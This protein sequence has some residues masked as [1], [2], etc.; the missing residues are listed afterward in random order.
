L[1]MRRPQ[2]LD[3]GSFQ[4]PL[5]VLE[6]DF[7]PRDNDDEDEDSPIKC[8]CAFTDVDG[9]TVLCEECDTWQHIA[10]Y[11]ESASHV[12][13][14]HECADC[15]PRPVDAKA[16]KEYQTKRRDQWVAAYGKHECSECGKAFTRANDLQRHQNSHGLSMLAKR[17]ISV[18]GPKSC[19]PTHMLPSLGAASNE[20]EQ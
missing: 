15:R 13:D 17:H 5:V 11:Y 20:S 1:L 12:P 18:V 19:D 3:L 4:P 7:D 9:Y 8:I 10:C 16:A 14:V 2:S 6:P